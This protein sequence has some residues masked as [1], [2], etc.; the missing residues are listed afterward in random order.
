MGIRTL[1][2]T[3]S[4]GYPSYLGNLLQALGMLAL[5]ICVFGRHSWGLLWEHL[6]PLFL[7]Q[8]A[9]ANSTTVDMLGQL[10]LLY[11]YNIFKHTEGQTFTCHS[12]KHSKD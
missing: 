6:G 11:Q 3:S 1:A 9:G 2:K 7:L 10:E 8:S 5:I 12:C 4:H